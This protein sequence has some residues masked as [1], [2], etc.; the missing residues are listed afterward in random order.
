MRLFWRALRS[1]S[2]SWYISR[3]WCWVM[4]VAIVVNDEYGWGF[5]SW[6]RDSVVGEAVFFEGGFDQRNSFG[7]Q[8]RHVLARDLHLPFSGEG[9]PRHGGLLGVVWFIVLHCH[10]STMFGDLI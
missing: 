1:S 6:I 9:W 5:G 4:V 10:V 8:I 2:V 3:R 7:I